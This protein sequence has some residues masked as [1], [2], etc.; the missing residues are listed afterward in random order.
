[1]ASTV[2]IN[3]PG[4]LTS[5]REAYN[6]AYGTYSRSTREK[7]LEF[8]AAVPGFDIKTHENTPQIELAEMYSFMLADS[9]VQTARIS[10]DAGTKALYEELKRKQARR[11]ES[12]LG[13][14][15]ITVRTREGHIGQLVGDSLFL[16]RKW[17][18]FHD[19]LLEYIVM[20]LGRDWFAAEVNKPAQERHQIIRLA[21]KVSDFQRRHIVKQGEVYSAVATAPAAAY[22]Q[23]AYDLYVI[24]HNVGLQKFMIDRLKQIEL[25][26]GA[27]YE[28]YV[29]ASL[30][31]G[32]F[33]VEYED[34]ADKTRSHCEYIATHNETGKK[35]SVEAKS[36]HRHG[37]WGYVDDRQKNPPNLNIKRLIK[38]AIK[39]DA[40]HP[41]AIFIDVNLPAEPGETFK[42][43]WAQ[44]SIALINK[45]ESRPYAKDREAYIF[46]TN[47]PHGHCADDEI[48][49]GNDAF[50]TAIGMP[51]FLVHDEGPV[52]KNHREMR[53]LIDFLV[54]HTQIP[55]AFDTDT[56]QLVALKNQA[57]S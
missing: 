41:K 50:M 27:R 14:D 55:N 20:V 13:R 16:S 48:D 33:S 51:E 3:R 40:P 52:N 6:F 7:L 43:S 9:I 2:L 42:K 10:D 5:F 17:K 32:G 28:L 37:V 30:I 53:R 12:G 21:E 15:P 25:F 45:L 49:L 11:R 4:K 47:A 34:E 38:D 29:A 26:Q 31:K 19:F 35:F 57:R 39:K 44:K 56:V 8:L 36:K 23:I 1:M 18:T 46:L 54:F 24:K 22:L